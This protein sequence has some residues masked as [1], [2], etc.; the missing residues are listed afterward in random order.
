MAKK[1][2]SLNNSR[3]RV[4]DKQRKA[5]A[6]IFEA[7]AAQSSSDIFLY[8]YLPNKYRI[9]IKEFRQKLRTMGIDNGRILDIHYPARGVVAIL[10]HYSYQNELNSILMKSTI[11]PIANF[12]LIA[13]EHVNDISLSQL[14]ADERAVKAIEFHQTRLI[15]GLKFIRS[16]LRRSVAR[17]FVNQGWI[18]EKQAQQVLLET[19][20]GNEYHDS[21]KNAHEMNNPDTVNRPRSGFSIRDHTQVHPQ[22]DEQMDI[23]EE[24]CNNSSAGVGQPAPRQ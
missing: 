24:T 12:N 16:Y 20:M 1:P 7:P 11:T 5:A 4:T 6:R 10:I 17:T 14:T 23:E 21:P 9:R 8:L 19:N 22:T 13:A 15:R 18:T 3:K 2:V